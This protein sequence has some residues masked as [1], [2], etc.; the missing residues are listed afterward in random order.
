[1]RGGRGGGAAQVRQR[2]SLGV[3]ITLQLGSGIVRVIEIWRPGAEATT[4]CW[5]REIIFGRDLQRKDPLGARGPRRAQR[6][7][8]GGG[9]DRRPPARP[10]PGTRDIRRILGASTP[11]LH[12]ATVIGWVGSCYNHGDSVVVGAMIGGCLDFGYWVDLMTVGLRPNQC[13]MV[14]S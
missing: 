10:P 8:P 13:E 5:V 9:P 7:G 2:D 4:I 6:S 12:D 11:G 3:A 14:H 1:M